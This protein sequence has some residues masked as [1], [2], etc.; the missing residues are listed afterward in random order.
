MAW[1]ASEAAKRYPRYVQEP[2]PMN[3]NTTVGELRRTLLD[4]VA[5]KAGIMLTEEE[6]I[7]HLSSA[8]RSEEDQGDDGD[9]WWTLGSESGIR[10]RAEEVGWDFM[11]LMHEIGATPDRLGS[12]ELLLER[13]RGDCIREGL[14]RAATVERRM[15]STALLL[16]MVR[17]ENPEG[18]ED[19]AP[20]VRRR[21]ILHEA[22]PEVRQ[23]DK[24]IR[25]ADLFNE[26]GVPEG[27]TDGS[28]LDQRFIDYLN[29]NPRELENMHWRQFEN[30][31]GEYFQ[32]AGY[33]VEVTAPRRDGGIDVYAK[34]DSGVAGPELVVIQAK[35]L[36]GGRKVSIDQVKAF[37]TDLE[38]KGA[39]RAVI[40]TTTRLEAG[41]RKL[42]ETRKYRMT[43][44]ERDEV[45]GWLKEM[46]PDT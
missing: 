21:F 30:L 11:A 19:I 41:A 3:I 37:W 28:Y 33:H 1:A 26:E 22:A 25:L 7:E 15:G 27:T 46:H 16:E 32:R 45:E 18:F 12:L 10:I 8:T 44:V 6:L 4:L 39:T 5:L 2:D 31:C 38:T 17:G 14:D 40:A 29:A 24:P 23:W 9:G 36:S 42:C 35:R 13:I 34:R 43:P 20:E